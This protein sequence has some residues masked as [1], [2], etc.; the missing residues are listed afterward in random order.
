[1]VDPHIKK[2]LLGKLRT[3]ISKHIFT[4][5]ETWADF[6]VPPKCTWREVKPTGPAGGSHFDVI[7]AFARHLLRGT[8]IVAS[9][10]E[11]INELELSN[12]MYLSGFNHSKLVEL[13][14]DAKAIDRLIA[15]L[16]RE[17]TG[18]KHLR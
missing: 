13:P 14:I 6:I 18:K 10:A 16:I 4:C 7:R 9:G 15:R 2:L 8:P 3:P 17:R 11:S 1:M 5:K 12:A